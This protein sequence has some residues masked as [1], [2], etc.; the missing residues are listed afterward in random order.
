M[1]DK[2]RHKIISAVLKTQLESIYS[3][4]VLI[5]IILEGYSVKGL[6]HMTDDELIEVYRD[7]VASWQDEEDDLLKEAE[8]DVA[9]EK[10]LTS[11]LE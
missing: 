8:S 10:M 2:L 11:N 9:I 1:N 3:R 4:E 7:D 5:E 6:N